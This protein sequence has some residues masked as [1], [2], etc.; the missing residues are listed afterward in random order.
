MRFQDAEFILASLRTPI[1]PTPGARSDLF[2][3]L[4]LALQPQCHLGQQVG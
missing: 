2:R 3:K 4:E 1:R